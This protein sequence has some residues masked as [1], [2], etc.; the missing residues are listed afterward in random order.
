MIGGFVF[1]LITLISYTFYSL[2]TERTLQQHKIDIRY[3]FLLFQM[4]L[5]LGLA[6]I[7]LA[8]F[9]RTPSLFN[10]LTAPAITYVLLCVC[11]PHT[12]YSALLKTKRFELFTDIFLLEVPLAM[13]LEVMILGTLLPPILYGVMGF[14][15]LTLFLLRWERIFVATQ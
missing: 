3:P 4:G 5:L 9:L 2:A 13:L 8:F 15:L 1:S 7:I 11:I 14:T 6:G 10:E 12:L